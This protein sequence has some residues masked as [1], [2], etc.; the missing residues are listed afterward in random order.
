MRVNPET[1]H[2]SLTPQRT[3]WIT[4]CLVLVMAPHIAR[5]PV[6]VLAWL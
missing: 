1:R 3:L 2:W 6:W 4:G 5:T